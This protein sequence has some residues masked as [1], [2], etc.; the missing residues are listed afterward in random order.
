M[1]EE[2]KT[3]LSVAQTLDNLVFVLAALSFL[4][5]AFLLLNRKK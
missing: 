2:L 3:L 1:V 5:A 4:C